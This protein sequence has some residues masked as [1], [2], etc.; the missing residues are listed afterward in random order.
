MPFLHC[1]FIRNLNIVSASP[2]KTVRTLTMAEESSTYS[3]GTTSYSRGHSTLIFIIMFFLGLVEVLVTPSLDKQGTEVATIV[4]CV[5]WPPCSR[6]PMVANLGQFFHL[7][8]FLNRLYLFEPI[9]RPCVSVGIS[10]C[11]ICHLPSSGNSQKQ[12]LYACSLDTTISVPVTGY[13]IPFSRHS[14]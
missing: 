10:H 2:T 4:L 6:A 7:F 13:M 9:E 8:S 3:L 11:L 14:S 12:V 5:L 1:Y